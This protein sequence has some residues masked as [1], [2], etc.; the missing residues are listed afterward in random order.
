[1]GGLRILFF[2]LVALHGLIHLLGFVKAY[3]WLEVKEL[4]M[5]ITRPVGIL[6][7]MAAILMLLY[8]FLCLNNHRYQHWL[9][10]LAILLSQGLIVYYWTDAKFGS[11]PNLMILVACLMSY[12]TTLFNSMVRHET[13]EIWNTS[14]SEPHEEWKTAEWEHL[15]IPVKRWL[16][17]CGATSRGKTY[18]GRIT[19]SAMM[20]MKPEQ[21]EWYE[22]KAFQ[23]TV[24]D[25][26]A[27]VWQVKMPM[28]ALTWVLGRDKFVKGK[29]EMLIKLNSLLNVVDEKGSKIDEGALQRFLGEM[30]WFPTLAVSPFV[31][32]TPID[33]TTAKATMSYEGTQGSGTFYFD[34]K[35]D[36]EKFVALR[37]LGGEPDSE[38][39]PWVLTVDAY[40][41]F[42]GIKVPSKMKATWKLDAEDWTWLMLT[43]D[44]IEYN[45]HEME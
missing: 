12:G 22:A 11:I 24:I 9:G 32:W 5:P 27:F 37:F 17:N 30:V 1:M 40:E 13:M 20:R 3:E 44:Q 26:P 31:S 25:E 28:N 6:W 45:V 36:F 29:G 8:F 43:I 23:Y 34:E 7:L 41:V 39:K 14:L 18:N 38:R 21:E 35:G 4:S 33:E 15:P 10:F 19:Q 16:K 2:I 42:E